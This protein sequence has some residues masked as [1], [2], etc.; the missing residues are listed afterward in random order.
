[1]EPKNLL[2][3]FSDQHNRNI[4]GCYGNPHIKT[5]NID[6]L[7]QRGVRFDNA[8]TNCPI[9]IPARASLATGRYVNEIG[10]WDNGI[11]YDGR[12]ASWHHRLRENGYTVD[13]VGKLHFRSHEDDN[14]FSKEMHTMHVVEGV[15]D[16]LGCIRDNPPKRDQPSKIRDAGPGDS[17]YIRYDHK[18]ADTA[19]SWIAEH[20]NDGK[21]WALFVGFV[22]PHP[23]YIAPER[24]FKLY[25]DAGLPMPPQWRTEDWPK[26]PALDQLR[27]FFMADSGISEQDIRTLH[28]AY[29]GAVS[30]MDWQTGRVLDALESAGLTDATRIVYSSDHGDSGGSRG[31]FGK[32][33]MYDESAAVPLIMSGPDIP[34][35]RS[36]TTPV[37]LADLFPTVLESFNVEPE[38]EDKD[39]PSESLWRFMEGPD[40]DR[41]RCVLSEYHA[42][43]SE[44]AWMLLRS[45]RYKY[46]YYVG[47]PPQLFDMEDDPQELVD[48]ADS[49]SHRTVLEDMDRKLREVVDPEEA[50][51]R[52][53]ADQKAMV[54]RHGGREK[55]IQRGTFHNTPTPDEP[56]VF[57]T[58]LK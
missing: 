48:L 14:G 53:K 40:A 18:V 32:F 7:A 17:S 2:F 43:G 11:P 29:Y 41:E 34:A 23:R 9:C 44:S 3:I 35:G 58:G 27:R 57:D 6:R 47:G 39:M 10:Y 1:M 38:E 51:R 12:V 26:H 30:Q 22:Q 42:L 8:Y 28:A 54:E 4:T 33:T 52:A 13:A 5:P 24:F 19:C 50:D 21:P 37:S 56:I 15:G 45:R 31:L 16:V 25:E 20:A 36:V 46:V 49:P 55:V